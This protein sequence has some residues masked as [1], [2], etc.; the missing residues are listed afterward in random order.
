MYGEIAAGGMATVH[1]G[2]LFGT[3]GFS[4]T[5][6]IKRLHPQFAKDPEFAA[7]FLD[8]AH[9]AASIR[10]PNVV[11]TLD[12]VAT[13][14]ELFIVMEYVRGE[15]LARLLSARSRGDAAPLRIAT[16]IIAGVL[17]GLHA[18]HEATS[19]AGEPLGI[20]HRDVSPQNVLVGCDGIARVLDFGIAKARDRIHVTRGGS[21]KGKVAYMS[22]EQLTG[23]PVDRRTDIHAAGVLLWEVLVGRRCFEGDGDFAT[24]DCV[25]S[26]AVE[27]P[28]RHAAGLPATVDAIVLRALAKDPADRFPTA[29]E[30]A[31]S[32]EADV[33]IEPPS[34]VGAWVERLSVDTLRTRAEQIA[35]IEQGSPWASR[36][37]VAL[38]D[39]DPDP[40]G[41]AP[42]VAL[43]RVLAPSQTGTSGALSQPKQAGK[44]A[45]RPAVL[46]ACAG[47]LAALALGIAAVVAGRT[48]SNPGQSPLFVAPS[49]AMLTP[50]SSAVADSIEPGASGALS[51]SAEA[52]PAGAPPSQ[53]RAPSRPAT[54]S[55]QRVDPCKPFAY[56]V[57]SR[58]IRHLKPECLR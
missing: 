49:A 40:D 8:E 21:L 33:G 41:A 3:A 56:T 39:D 16:A 43:D 54:G 36:S 28:S 1:Y 10:H 2:R 14:G 30:M 24:A 4:R 50:A 47:G 6:A 7:M 48:Q 58:G 31:L 22:P 29:R 27:P 45:R 35:R 52:P 20:V 25:K 26:K 5:V 53:Q 19:D 9:L 42:T 13:G 32:L 17:H 12:V 38:A 15:T 18:A 23:A 51:A 44:L 34:S 46:L 57:D 11:P 55:A 37:A